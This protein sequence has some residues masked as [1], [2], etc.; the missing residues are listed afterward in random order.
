M[1]GLRLVQETAVRVLESVPIQDA[2]RAGSQDFAYV[3]RTS[4]RR[5]ASACA[6]AK[7]SST[8]SASSESGMSLNLLSTK[9]TVGA[10]P[11][12]SMVASTTPSLDGAVTESECICARALVA[13][14]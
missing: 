12:T 11:L 5:T 4:M 1:S 14:S 6:V 8:S 10:V 7:A 3:L 13:A 9:R 2:P